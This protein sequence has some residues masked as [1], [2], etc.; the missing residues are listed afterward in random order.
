MSS[1]MSIGRAAVLA[2][3]C[4]GLRALAVPLFDP[5]YNQSISFTT[6]GQLQQTMM[7]LA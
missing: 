5:S 4:V 3:L 7:T 2:Q 6:P 1:I